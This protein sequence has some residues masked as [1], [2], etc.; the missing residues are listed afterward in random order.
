MWKIMMGYLQKW[1]EVT[2]NNGMVILI[3]RIC[4]EM[5]DFIHHKPITLEKLLISVIASLKEF[6][7][8]NKWKL[9]L[10]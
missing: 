1:N 5:V 10:Q 7:S 3:T 4:Y 2:V 6:L 8:S 9:L